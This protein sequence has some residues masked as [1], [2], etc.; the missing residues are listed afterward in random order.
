MMRM[1]EFSVTVAPSENIRIGNLLTL[2]T[3][4]THSIPWVVLVMTL[5]RGPPHG[6]Y[7]VMLLRRV[8]AKRLKE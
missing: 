6:G 7:V 1:V 8:V 4:C 5:H 2:N 3:L